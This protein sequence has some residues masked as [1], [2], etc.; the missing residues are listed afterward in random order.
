MPKY[1]PIV[2]AIP[3][4]VPTPAGSEVQANRL[5][6]ETRETAERASEAVAAQV[7]VREPARRATEIVI[8]GLL[9]QV[10]ETSRRAVEDVSNSVTATAIEGAKRAVDRAAVDVTVREVA[11]RAG[12]VVNVEAVM[13]ESARRAAASETASAMATANETAKR[14]VEGITAVVAAGVEKAKRAADA[15][16]VT[17]IVNA[18]ANA[19]SSNTGWVN[20]NSALG[21]TPSVS[22]TLTATSSGV[23]GTTSNTTTGTLVLALPD[24]AITDL[25]LGA[26]SLNVQRQCTVGGTAPIGQSVSVQFQYSLNGT[27]WTTFLTVA[28]ALGNGTTSVDITGVI[29]GSYANLNALQVRATGTVVS[30]TGLGATATVA[31]FRA[32]LSFAASK[33]YA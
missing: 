30:G 27:S 4:P 31:W 10:N 33:E 29:A 2:Q 28:A 21:N 3:V 23:A 6:S 8:A 20:P 22:A 17:A 14:A 15:A 13:R 1:F 18:Y 16:S 26:V 25:A 11:R 24:L 32:W 7:S 5:I 9:T 12:E 19:V